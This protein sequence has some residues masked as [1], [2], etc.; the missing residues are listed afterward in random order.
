VENQIR[1]PSTFLD[2]FENALASN[3]KGKAKVGEFGG[4]SPERG[5]S[6]HPLL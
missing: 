2:I 6:P 1:P 3:D 4:S 5:F